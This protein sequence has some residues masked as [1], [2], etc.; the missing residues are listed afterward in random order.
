VS[1]IHTSDPKLNSSEAQPIVG[2]I[3]QLNTDG[4]QIWVY[5]SGWNYQHIDFTYWFL[6]NGIHPVRAYYGYFM[7]TSIAPLFNVG[8]TSYFTSDYLIDTKYLENGQD[9]FPEYTYKVDNISVYKPVN[10]LPSVYVIHGDHLVPAKI[11][12]FTPDEITV[13]GQFS[14]GDFVGLKT[15]FYPGWKANGVDMKN[16]GNMPTVTLASNTSSITFRYDP[17]DFKAGLFF[18]AVGLFALLII[19]IRRNEINT[20]LLAAS[21]IPE[22]IEEPVTKKKSKKR[23]R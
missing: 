14:N 10:V 17:L 1:Y 12:K 20:Y 8:N 23:R 3:N 15:A 5:E 7:K 9:N 13:T 6:K 21:P 11:E 19:V 2:L 4:H 18:T 22:V 16:I